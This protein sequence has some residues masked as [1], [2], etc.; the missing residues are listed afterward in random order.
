[1]KS[2]SKLNR[3]EFERD[4]QLRMLMEDMEN[5]GRSTATA[6]ETEDESR[7]PQNLGSLKSVMS[8]QK[9]EEAQLR[10]AYRLSEAGAYFPEGDIDS[11]GNEGEKGNSHNCVIRR[12]VKSGAKV[13]LRPVVRTEL[14]PHTIANEQDGTEITSETISLSKFLH[15]FTYIMTT[16][17]GL[18]AVGRPN[19]LHA[20]TWVLDVVP[21]AEART[22]H[23]LV[24]VKLEQG[25]IHWNT[26]FM[27]LAKEHIEMKVRQSL[28]SRTQP[29]TSRSSSG[30]R[31]GQRSFSRGGFRS[32]NSN[33]GSKSR[34][35][36]C[37]QWNE[38]SCTYG[39]KCKRWHVCSACGE[40]GKVG[41]PHKSSSS[42][43]PSSKGNQ[44]ADSK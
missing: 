43:C 5:R 40:A 17:E 16:C 19:L 34:F 30:Y 32:F 42:D 18:E 9:Q 39:A 33:T 10:L 25:R 27:F 44:R 13:R 21:W 31:T 8:R 26:D 24:M 36:Y 7:E 14:W 37:R 6:T 41:E 20:I 28:R 12:K 38:G 2:K 35:V 3:V 4:R 1:M 23:N 15:C 22:F 11:S 29:S